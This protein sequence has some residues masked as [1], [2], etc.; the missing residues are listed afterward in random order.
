MPGKEKIL[1]AL[2]EALNKENGLM[3]HDFKIEQ[4]KEVQFGTF[5]EID[6]TKQDVCCFPVNPYKN[7]D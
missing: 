6:V 5:G 7:S 3:P 2:Y 4:P 1:I